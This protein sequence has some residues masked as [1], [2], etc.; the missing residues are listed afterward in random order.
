[1]LTTERT[2]CENLG[3][4]LEVLV[5]PLRAHEMFTALGEGSGISPDVRGGTGEGTQRG[6]NIIASNFVLLETIYA[7]HQHFLELFEKRMKD[8]EHLD[9]QLGDIVVQLVTHTLAP[10]A[11]NVSHSPGALS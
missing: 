4:A 8:L 2:Y 3:I 7:F 10:L 5:R 1:M 6:K 9:Y 11:L